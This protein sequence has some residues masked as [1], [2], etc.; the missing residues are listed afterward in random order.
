MPIEVATFGMGCFWG[1][2][3]VFSK[4]DGV[5]STAVG[6]MGGDYENPTYKDVCTGKTGHAEV[7]Q[8]LYDPDRVSYEQLLKVFWENHDPTT[9]DRQGPDVGSQYRSVI[10]YHTPAQREAA[11]KMKEQFDRSGRFKRPVVTEIS[12]ASKFY[13]AEEYHQKYFERH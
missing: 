12:P 9:L 5:L 4:V 7:V 3:H 6:Y 1:A 13:R 11:L 10:F 8:V 2:E